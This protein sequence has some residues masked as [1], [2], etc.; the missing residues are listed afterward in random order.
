M[1]KILDPGRLL[2]LVYV[3][4]PD[5]QHYSIYN[6]I[7]MSILAPQPF[8]STILALFL[9]SFFLSSF[10][11]CLTL[12]PLHLNQS[13]NTTKEDSKVIANGDIRQFS[14]TTRF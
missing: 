2:D 7:F 3:F 4:V 6:H 12:F 8:A 1:E 5:L 11:L 13:Q 14:I 9:S 10:F